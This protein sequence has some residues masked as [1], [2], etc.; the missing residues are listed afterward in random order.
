MTR[1]LRALVV[2]DEALLAMEMERLLE[3]AG[4]TVAAV[5][6][7]TAGALAAAAGGPD[8]AFV[9]VNLRDGRTGPD[10]AAALI[11]RGV[12]CVFVTADPQLLPAD[13]AGALGV[14]RKPYAPRTLLAV[15]TFLQT[16]LEQGAQP[17]PAPYG[18]TL[19]SGAVVRRR[20]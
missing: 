18:L 14:L 20:Q 10:I 1:A 15:L 12:P 7:E 16:W 2:E 19:G 4:W 13:L 17:G 9:D 11:E 6:V 3:Q 8:L 5:A